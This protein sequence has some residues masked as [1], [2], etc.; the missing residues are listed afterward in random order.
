MR[1]HL[2]FEAS[3]RGRKRTIGNNWFFGSIHD[4]APNTALMIT[5]RCY[6]GP[7]AILHFGHFSQTVRFTP[8]T[9]FGLFPLPLYH[10]SRSNKVEYFIFVS[11]R[12]YR[13][14]DPDLT[15][16]LVPFRNKAD[17]A[18]LDA[19]IARDA[20]AATEAKLEAANA[21]LSVSEAS[22]TTQVTA[23]ADTASELEDL[24]QRLDKEKCSKEVW[25]ARCRSS[26]DQV[27]NL[28]KE[29]ERVKTQPQRD[30]IQ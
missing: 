13:K 22:S 15:S 26:Q 11:V 24:R 18:L 17:E 1:D 20:L 3:F 14:W 19:R 6:D 12:E 29:L 10:F 8:W 28:T 9:S 5:I 2:V 30:G 27:K 4:Y 23:A 7:F 16:I 21:K 25:T